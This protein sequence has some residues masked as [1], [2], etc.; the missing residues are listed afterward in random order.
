MSLLMRRALVRNWDGVRRA[1]KVRDA[2][3]G[4]SARFIDILLSRDS[5][6]DQ[7]KYGK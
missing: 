4:I 1:V 6:R 3:R 7:H 5:R 2:E